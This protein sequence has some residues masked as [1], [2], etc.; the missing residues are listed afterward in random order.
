MLFGWYRILRYHPPGFFF[1]ELKHKIFRE[2]HYISFTCSLRRIDFTPYNSARSL[3]NITFRPRNTKILLKITCWGTTL[4]VPIFFPFTPVYSSPN[5][6]PPIDSAP[7]RPKQ[8][9][10]RPNRSRAYDGLRPQPDPGLW[11]CRQGK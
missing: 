8:S 10:F 2:A 4:L 7:A 3:S 11:A 5:N 9:R 6:P 1:R